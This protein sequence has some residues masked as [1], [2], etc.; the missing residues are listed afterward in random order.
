MKI[1]K[2]VFFGTTSALGLS[3][4]YSYYYAFTKIMD[5]DTRVDAWVGIKGTERNLNYVSWVL[6]ATSYLTIY[7]YY[8]KI[9]NLINPTDMND[10]RPK[11][12][13]YLIVYTG[14]LGFSALWGPYTAKYINKKNGKKDKYEKYYTKIG[15]AFILTMVTYFS[16]QN[17]HLLN[18][19][20]YY[21]NRM[22]IQKKYEV[23]DIDS[24]PIVD[25]TTFIRR[26]AKY[27][28]LYL[29]FHVGVVDNILWLR[30]FWKKY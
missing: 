20:K 4:L 28:T 17:Q 29:S 30:K 23:D 12:L 18:I 25:S 27:S 19:T 8:F 24:A 7:F 3:V 2:T 9:F 14:F 6:A 13:D 22:N 21:Y 26:Y 10:R 1:S 16:L 5:K 15:V 11:T